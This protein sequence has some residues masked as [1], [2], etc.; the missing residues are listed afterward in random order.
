[1]SDMQDILEK[2]VNRLG[3]VEE[4]ARAAKTAF[5]ISSANPRI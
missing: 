2:L 4:E 1:M 3:R 5:K